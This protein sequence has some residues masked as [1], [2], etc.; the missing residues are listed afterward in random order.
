MR[1]TLTALAGLLLLSGCLLVDDFGDGW[2]HAKPDMCISRIAPAIYHSEFNRDPG[3]ATMNDRA[4]AITLGGQHF[5]LLKQSAGDAGGRL[6]RF[7]V[8]SGIFVRYRLAPTQRDAFEKEFPNAPVSIKR[9]TVTL[10]TLDEPVKKL[11][12]AVAKR[13]QY[14]EVE[15]KVLYNPLLNPACRFEDRDLSKL[16]QFIRK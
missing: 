13:P 14:W 10:R 5:L 7:R 2:T 4:R 9:D 8:Q 6:Y 16:Q 3:T 12:I 15:D 11:L 1:R